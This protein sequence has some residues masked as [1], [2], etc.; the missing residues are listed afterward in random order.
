[1]KR[2]WRSLTSIALMVFAIANPLTT[3]AED[4]PQTASS[5]TFY[6]DRTT[7]QVFMRPG[8]NRTALR[9]SG[10]VDAAAVTRQ[11]ERQVEQKTDAR[12]Q[13]ALAK[14]QAQ[15]QSEN[16]ALSKK[17]TALEPAWK[18][19]LDN[20]QDKFRL[21]ALAYLDYAYY[22]HTGYGPYF[23]ENLNPPGV[24]NNGYNSFDVN[25]ACPIAMRSLPASPL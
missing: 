17:L 23:L 5:V 15:Q 2:R 3:R 19:Y 25:R 18:N 22:T 6:V 16:Q 13:A 7:G 10:A 21:G 20:F 14:A 4:P 12:L 24:G 9:V 1:M 8:P 11:V